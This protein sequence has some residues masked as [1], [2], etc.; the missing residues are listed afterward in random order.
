MPTRTRR[1]IGSI[2]GLLIGFASPGGPDAFAAAGLSE[3]S[4]SVAPAVGVRLLLDR[5]IDGTAAP[6]VLASADGHFRAAGLNV[7]MDTASGSDDA[8]ARVA[9]RA[10]DF[11]LADI[12]ALIRFRDIANAPP[13]K[14]VFMLFNAAPYAIIARKSRG[15]RSLA[16]LESK[17]IGA[18]N[19]DLAIR[20][21]PALAQKNGVKLA[22]V[23]RQAIGA[24]VREP[25]LS[26]GQVDAVTGFSYLSAVN[27][28][29]R[30]VPA[31]DLAVLRFADY[32]SA[33]YGAA[34]IV[35]P[36]FATEHPEAVT[37]FLQAVVT[38]LQETIRDPEHAIDAV[39]VRMEGASRD[40][41][42]ER[43]KT[44]IDQDLVTDEVKRN[45]FGAID[46]GRLTRSITEIAVDHK[47]RHRPTA[48]DIFDAAFLPAAD[49][50][51]LTQ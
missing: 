10:A 18:A 34:L 49:E 28:R 2:F 20:L 46:T 33:A 5:P 3:A 50:R 38:G 43:L 47:F 7:T 14:A 19:G 36:A 4:V 22:A 45:G 41:E 9:A 17:T 29:D 39:M 44:A 23:R 6:F 48:P 13:V 27:L 12:N 21:W 30:G 26:A 42:R 31:D 8:I 16:D 25:M 32:G 51:Q 37:P 15:I 35:N 40:L 24:A 11:A 1:L